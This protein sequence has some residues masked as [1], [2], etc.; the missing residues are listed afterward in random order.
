M[1]TRYYTLIALLA[2]L[3]FTGA[4]PTQSQAG[5]QVTLHPLACTLCETRIAPDGKTAAIFEN[6][7]IA[8]GEVTAPAQIAITL[9]DIASGK[10]LGRLTGQTDFTSDAA[11]A[12]D[13]RW[14]VSLHSNG[15]LRLWE[16]KTRKLVWDRFVGA[17]AGR[18]AFSA[19]GKT[20]V[21]SRSG[22]PNALW[23]MDRQS[24]AIHPI[25][26]WRFETLA[27]FMQLV[28]NAQGSIGLNFSA[29]ALSPDGKQAAV[30]TASD[31]VWLFDV[32]EGTAALAL[33]GSDQPGLFSIRQLGY[34]PDG[35][36][37]YFSDNR[38]HSPR[39]W[40]LAAMT[41]TL[42]LAAEAGEDGAEPPPFDLYGLALSP[43]GSSFAWVDQNEEAG[44]RGLPQ[45]LVAPV[46]DWSQPTHVIDLPAHLR[47]SP[48]VRVFWTPD[49]RVIA[50]GFVTFDGDNVLVV[51]EP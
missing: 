11:F 1:M 47:A 36:S 48:P 22:L 34:T 43:D 3:L 40:S 41:D 9:I 16:V 14:L 32:A 45:L 38:T 46:D 39:L 10:T 49:G 12:P 27:E 19:N 42:P 4:Q 28:S 8:G 15:S 6:R 25:L 50:G 13:C 7:D 2:F 37:L 26:T 33:A 18:V 51:V 23:F 5:P 31:E 17:G 29:W 24:G 21:A 20:I 44:E 30:A 35:E